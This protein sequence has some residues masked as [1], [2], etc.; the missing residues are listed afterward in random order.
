M[1]VI[2]LSVCESE[3]S[4]EAIRPGR[5][6]NISF[7]SSLNWDDTYMTDTAGNGTIK[8]KPL[9]KGGE[10]ELDQIVGLRAA[11]R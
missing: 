7:S 3:R 11:T 1:R 5:A 6:K 8:G 2:E 10:A 4:W 9:E